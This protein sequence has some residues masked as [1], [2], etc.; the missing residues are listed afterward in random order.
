M[1][2]KSE[3]E[4]E[5]AGRGADPGVRDRVTVLPASGH[6][7]SARSGPRVG[8]SLTGVARDALSLRPARNSQSG[9]WTGALPGS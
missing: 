2:E 6:Q 1:F 7:I 5:E 3:G 8:C 4:G 9:G